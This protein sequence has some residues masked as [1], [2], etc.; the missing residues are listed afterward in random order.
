ILVTVTVALT[1]FVALV[2]VVQTPNRSHNILIPRHLE[3]TQFEPAPPAQPAGATIA[4][5]WADLQTQAGSDFLN[6]LLPTQSGALWIP[7][8]VSLLVGF[9]YS[10]PGNPRNLELVALLIVGFLLF[11]VIRFFYNFTD[12]SYFQLMD[13]VFSGVVVTSVWLAGGSVWRVWHPYRGPWKPNLP[14]R[15]LVLLTIVLLAMNAL[16]VMV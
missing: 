11:D 13:W 16:V 2:V 5:L 14:T 12:P 1:A 7:L 15:A 9:D 4:R 10:Q 6:R 8:I 3:H